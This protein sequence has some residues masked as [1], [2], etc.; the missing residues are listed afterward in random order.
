MKKLLFVCTGNTCRSPMA[1]FY[2]NHLAK[3]KN[4][5]WRADS[6][7]FSGYGDP[8]APHAITA[9][10][11]R[12]IAV[13]PYTSKRINPEHIEQS[14]FILCMSEQHRTWLQTVGLPTEKVAVLGDGIADPYGGD[15]QCYQ[16]CLAE[17]EAAL[18]SLVD[19]GIF[20]D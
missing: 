9:L 4:L 5:H 15:E 13:A 19:G 18:F 14:D 16:V 7:G 3:E 2:F 8:M 6:A 17:L 20:D 1:M 12:G 10:T 11:D